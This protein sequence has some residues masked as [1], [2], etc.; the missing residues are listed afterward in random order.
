MRIRLAF[1][2]LSLSCT[3]NKTVINACDSDATEALCISV[4]MAKSHWCLEKHSSLLS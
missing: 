4:Q 1:Y 3:Y 2:M